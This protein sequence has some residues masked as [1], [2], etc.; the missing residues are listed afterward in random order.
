[1]DVTA[2]RGRTARFPGKNATMATS[3][4]PT[5]P[6]D[7]HRA[8]SCSRWRRVRKQ[9]LSADPRPDYSKN[10]YEA[11]LVRYGLWQ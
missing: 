4:A 8:V 5:Q 9:A 1:M 2:D 3:R 7:R 10:R 6:R 11:S